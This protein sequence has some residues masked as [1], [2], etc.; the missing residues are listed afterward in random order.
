MTGRLAAMADLEG[1]LRCDY[2]DDVMTPEHGH[3]N[4]RL[5]DHRNFMFTR[6]KLWINIVDACR[7]CNYYRQA[8]ARLTCGEYRDH[9]GAD[10]PVLLGRFAGGVRSGGDHRVTPKFTRSWP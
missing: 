3:P 5:Y 10:E 7:T 6:R 2:C 4:S 1:N 9:R 8:I